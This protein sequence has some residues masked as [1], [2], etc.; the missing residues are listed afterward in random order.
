MHPKNRV[1][2]SLQLADLGWTWWDND[3]NSDHTGTHYTDR[4]Q[5]I[6]LL[7]HISAHHLF[8]L[9]HK[10]IEMSTFFFFVLFLFT[11]G[12]LYFDVPLLDRSPCHFNLFYFLGSERN[13]F[14]EFMAIGSFA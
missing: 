4:I 5:S 2:S 10:E 1:A 8:R 7:L 13:Y 12:R 9:G 3:N 14:V 6:L 11:L